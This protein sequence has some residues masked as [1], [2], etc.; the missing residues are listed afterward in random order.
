VRVRLGY[1][2]DRDYFYATGG[3]A[4]GEVS[5]SVFATTSRNGKLLA[6]YFGSESDTRAGWTAGA[7]YEFAFTRIVSAKVEYLH[8]DLGG[9]NYSVL[10]ASGGAPLPRTWGASDRISGDIVRVGINFRFY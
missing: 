6:T 9:S 3:V 4:F 10:L 5:S 1:A 2:L 8:F 7:G